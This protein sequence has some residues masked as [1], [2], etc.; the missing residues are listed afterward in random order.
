MDELQI[1]NQRLQGLEDRIRSYNFF[2]FMGKTWYEWLYPVDTDA[3]NQATFSLINNS[4]VTDMADGSASLNFFSWIVPRDLRIVTMEFVWSTLASSG[5]LK[6]DIGVD[7]GQGGEAQN[8]RTSSSTGNVTATTGASVL[9]FT[10]FDDLI[11]LRQFKKGDVV[12]IQLIRQGGQAEDTLS[13]LAYL[14]GIKI[15][16]K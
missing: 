14:H 11:D 3:G 12:G 16:Y 6:W 9:H 1:L 8:V 10:R 15:T 2:R 4:P 5:N 7:G 13:A